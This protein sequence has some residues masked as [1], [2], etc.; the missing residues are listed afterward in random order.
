MTLVCEMEWLIVAEGLGG[1]VPVLH[2]SLAEINASAVNAGWSA[3][4]HA[5]SD[6]AVCGK[7]VGNA[8]SCSFS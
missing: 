8:L 3:R 4:F 5:T 1:V 2:L 6:E 7:L